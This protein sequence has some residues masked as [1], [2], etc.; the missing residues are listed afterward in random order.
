MLDQEIEILISRYA[1]DADDLT[2]D[3]LLRVRTVV[4]SD[5]AARELLDEYESL[6]EALRR[7]APAVPELDWERLHSH[8]SAAMND[9]PADDARQRMRIGA[10]RSAMPMTMPMRWALAASVLLCIGLA[11][12][13]T[14]PAK[15]AGGGNQRQVVVVPPSGGTDTVATL[16]NVSG[17]TIDL[18]DGAV[19]MD[20]SIGQPTMTAESAAAIAQDV[21][22]RPAQINIVAAEAAAT[23]P[24]PPRQ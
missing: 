17:P 13:A 20:V 7:A 12:L 23:E 6:T 24:L 2:A 16:I 11:L 14:Q 21:V 18:P 19:Q 9:A 15:F 8:L 10:G 1:D 3:E 22:W 4:A 5:P